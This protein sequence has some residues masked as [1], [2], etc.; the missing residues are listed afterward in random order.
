ML[1]FQNDSITFRYVIG[2]IVKYIKPFIITVKII[3]FSAAVIAC[4]N[5]FITKHLCHIDHLTFLPNSKFS[6]S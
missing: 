3:I 2:N 1:C 6:K 5:R 4:Y